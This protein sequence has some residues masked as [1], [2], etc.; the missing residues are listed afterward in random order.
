[1]RISTTPSTSRR[2]RGVPANSGK[3]AWAD[4]LK[5]RI[6]CEMDGR[7]ERSVRRD[8]VEDAGAIARVRLVVAIRQ[9]CLS[10]HDWRGRTRF[11][12]SRSVRSLCTSIHGGLSAR[13]LREEN[14]CSI[15]A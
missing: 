7:D 9:A 10:G 2:K 5:P 4:A 11:R 6:R 1:M 12:A 14:I 13:I 3:L 8:G 15:I